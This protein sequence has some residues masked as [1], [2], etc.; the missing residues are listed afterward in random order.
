MDELH[1]LLQDDEEYNV[2]IDRINDITIKDPVH[3]GNTMPFI[4]IDDFDH[5]T[6]LWV[7]ENRERYST[8]LSIDSPLI[9][10]IEPTTQ[11]IGGNIA[12]VQFMEAELITRVQADNIIL[13]IASNFGKVVHPGY[14]PPI[15]TPGKSQQ[16]QEKKKA[17]RKQQGNGT[18]MSSQISFIIRA[19]GV[20]DSPREYPIV[21]KVMQFPTDIL[22]FKIKVF[23][24]GYTQIPGANPK[25]INGVVAALSYVV[26]YL[27]KYLTPQYSIR[28]I[29]INPIMYNYKFE[30]IIPPGRIFDVRALSQCALQMHTG[31]D[32]LVENTSCGTKISLQFIKTVGAK[33]YTSTF[34]IFRSGK[35][36]IQGGVNTEQIK[37]SCE[38][39]IHV[40]EVH[41]DLILPRERHPAALL[42]AN[43]RNDLAPI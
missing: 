39:L 17:T 11:T 19:D 29:N 31:P 35:C 20:G 18:Q 3:Q 10:Q 42:S 26:E 8:S 9:T 7:A 27:S 30:V 2:A 21:D 24:T 5:A 34:A 36:N 25:N 13:A 1:K 12:N 32:I 28:V 6:N 38:Y 15:K 37:H 41:Y 4:L 14:T 23:R 43:V 40:L 16:R 33:E 22:I